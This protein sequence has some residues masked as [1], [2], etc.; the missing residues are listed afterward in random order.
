MTEKKTTRQKMVIEVD[1]KRYT[2]YREIIGLRKP[3]QKVSFRNHTIDDNWTYASWKFK[4]PKKVMHNKAKVL[5][6]KLVR[7][8]RNKKVQPG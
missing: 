4:D 3:H 7:Q 8:H 2:G 6:R 1:G 5:L